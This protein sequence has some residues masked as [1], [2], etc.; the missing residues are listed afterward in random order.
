MRVL[1]LGPVAVER[2]GERLSLGRAKEAAVL[3][4]LAIEAGRPVP[5]A[6]LVDGVWGDEP[7]PTAVRTLH[8]YVAR[9]RGRLGADHLRRS[10]GGY[11]LAGLR[12]D[13]QEV[14]QALSSA[15]HLGP[16]LEAW[17]GEPL[18]GLPATPHLDAARTRFA[19]L[20]STVRDRHYEV[21]LDAGADDALVRE[22]E[23]SVAAEPFRELRWAQ[24]MRALYRVGRQADA[25]EAYQ[26][27]RRLLSEELGLEP[28]PELAELERDIL[29]Q[30][31]RLD[32]R[33][34]PPEGPVVLL[35]VLAVAPGLDSAS[36]PE[37][38]ARLKRAA[39]AVF[40]DHGGVEV[41]D[42][43]DG[44][45][46]AF[47]AKDAALRAATQVVTTGTEVR[48]GLVA[49]IGDRSDP[50]YAATA[51]HIAGRVATAA[52]PGQVLV[53]AE[54]ASGGLPEGTAADELGS[55]W[56]R[57]ISVPVRLSQLVAPGLVT[58]APRLPEAA[59]RAQHLPDVAAAL[60]GRDEELTSV[61]R[62]LADHR[63]VTLTGPGGVGK[64]R[65]AEAA[66]HALLDRYRDGCWLVELASAGDEQTVLL[67]AAAA[68]G[69][70]V[71]DTPLDGIVGALRAMR[72]LLVI[73]NCE[74]VA[75]AAQSLVAT[76]LAAC[77]G[78]DVLATSRVP[79]DV[80]S[81][82]AL[83]LEP[84]SVP[85]AGAVTDVASASPYASIQLFVRRATERRA[86]FTP[87]DADVVAMAE[88]ARRV[89]GLPLAIE[90]AAAQTDL[91]TPRQ[92]ADRL[93][94]RME[95]ADASGRHPDRHGSLESTIAWSHGLLSTTEKRVLARLSALPGDADLDLLLAVGAH[96]LSPGDGS[97]AAS[98]LV[99]A[100][101]LSTRAEPSG[102]RYRL[103]E[104]IRDYADTGWTDE[105]DRRATR[106]RLVEWSL[107]R[108]TAGP[109]SVVA[110]DYV[111]HRAA[112]TWALAGGDARRGIDL[113][114]ALG[115]LWSTVGPLREGLELLARAESMVG[116][117][118]ARRLAVVVTRAHL[119]VTVGANEE[120]RAH[121]RAAER[122]A[123]DM[124]DT[125]RLRRI[126][127]TTG[128]VERTHL[129]LAEAR[130]HL[131]EALELGGGVVDGAHGTSLLQ[132][133]FC[134]WQEG[135]GDPLRR[136]E[137]A[138]QALRAAQEPGAP[139]ADVVRALAAWS[140]GATVDAE[141]LF[142]DA[143]QALRHEGNSRS[144]GIISG[145]L[146][147]LASE[148]G[149]PAAVERYLDEGR[150]T[151]ERAGFG[152]TEIAPID[153]RGLLAR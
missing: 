127:N 33:V 83:P 17:F 29:V 125:D 93:A 65:L 150:Q 153:Y 39:R 24:L 43:G 119:E 114:V 86:S 70:T 57:D 27:L 89:D 97:A 13:V 67:A 49:A 25:L 102:M 62:L 118:R 66:A 30:S 131:E 100:A 124:G 63:L 61:Q 32:P 35:A 88:I 129:E 28:G 5:I 90:L 79:L 22:L 106:Q 52:H 16:V 75:E 26:R 140:S 95:L 58:D 91:L 15:A 82:V 121:L 117:D 20:R 145:F 47:G 101:M 104:L 149:D 130:R 18:A 141:R 19:E 142:I 53:T 38:L 12:T 10:A 123:R 146:A 148:R 40:R 71:Q 4:L 108:V 60:L 37:R 1:L 51:L 92:I 21:L 138:Q 2:D 48:V 76:V 133:A 134:D 44:L 81:Q 147:G 55:F 3:A 77:S 111:N 96:D 152:F 139:I 143:R 136:A 56:L 59:A 42:S 41:R 69:V 7:P 64:T 110:R 74:H 72:C 116:Q 11:A 31:P 84:L 45:V 36:Y 94:E 115:E 73:D 68:L 50:E 144:V 8:A 98:G 151:L 6:T 122:L 99:R 126:L 105:A 85:A 103:L 109:V 135:V 128:F 23:A 87:T 113:A 78:V 9:L 120:A 137:Q 34:P 107:D 112:L 46:A 80:P 132:L 14:E 54:V